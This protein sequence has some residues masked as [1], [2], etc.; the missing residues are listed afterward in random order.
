MVADVEAVKNHLQGGEVW[1]SF[2]HLSEILQK[3][4]FHLVFE[5]REVTVTTAF[6]RHLVE[7]AGV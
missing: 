4:L 7:I 6:E 3:I 2:H 5:F 1:A